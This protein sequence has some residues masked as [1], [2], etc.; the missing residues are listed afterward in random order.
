MI[1]SG[2]KRIPADFCTFPL[3]L[4]IRFPATMETE[5]PENINHLQGNCK[6]ENSGIYSHI[7]EDTGVVRNR[8]TKS[9]KTKKILST[10]IN[11]LLISRKENIKNAIS[12]IAIP[13]TV[14]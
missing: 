14:G 5:N 12:T 9:N 13:C 3:K 8:L 4:P 7:N 10:F 1:R 11:F 2:I 6:F